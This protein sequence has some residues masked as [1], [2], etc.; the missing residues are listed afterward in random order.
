MAM[1]S[2]AASYETAPIDDKDEESSVGV[3]GWVGFI[4]VNFAALGFVSAS[5]GVASFMGFS[6]LVIYTG[7]LFVL[8]VF[9][10]RRGDQYR[11]F[12]NL[13]WVLGCT[14]IFVVGTM[15]TLLVLFPGDSQGLL[16]WSNPVSAWQ[17]IDD[18]LC[19]IALPSGSGAELSSWAC[20]P[21]YGGIE[22]VDAMQLG[23]KVFFTAR[24][25]DEDT[26]SSRLL[27]Y[28]GS[29]SIGTVQPK[30][31]HP[32]NFVKFDSRLYVIASST[33]EW[34]EK[35]V[36][37]VGDDGKSHQVTSFTANSADKYNAAPWDLFVPEDDSDHLY[38]KGYQ[39]CKDV[40][41]SFATI[42]N[43]SKGSSDVVNMRRPG[44]CDSAKGADMSDG[45]D[46]VVDEPLT[47]EFKKQIA[48]SLFLGVVPMMGVAAW[49]LAKKQM[50]GVFLNL[51]VG[52]ILL[53]NM[54]MVLADNHSSG[55]FK[56][57]LTLYT[58]AT[59]ACLLVVSIKFEQL[60]QWLDELKTWAVVANST[61]FFAVLHWQ[62]EIPITDAVWPW[63]LYAFFVALQIAASF[64]VMRS[65]PM[66]L[67]AVSLFILAWKVSYEL[68]DLFGIQYGLRY[69]FVL[70]VLMILGVG[71]IIA[72]I[73]YASRRKAV[74]QAVKAFI[75][76]LRGRSGGDQ[77]VALSSNF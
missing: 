9:L 72:S 12:I 23:N 75:E 10:E 55:F 13:F 37:Y 73:M 32:S 64:V 21:R 19:K 63:W 45:S 39:W 70:L 35:E 68:V 6:M 66:I 56:W 51:F 59:W 11:Q 58:T 30:L 15:F 47:G 8:A 5:F 44:F 69:M 25:E 53:V 49:A 46:A 1:T 34:H 41:R 62:L 54:L 57:F 27:E 42:Y 14:F 16:D 29:G 2:S 7:L 38:I 22:G 26:G 17:P 67:S 40:Q 77:E 43:I 52:V 28:F 3:I 61:A 71:I 36:F 24:K 65:Y 4:I 18:D 33:S 76:G 31:S 60:E 74:D 50:P 20:E 48:G